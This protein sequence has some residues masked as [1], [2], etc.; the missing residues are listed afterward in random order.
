M[1]NLLALVAITQF[2]KGFSP[3][4]MLDSY[5][6]IVFSI[7][8]SLCLFE[9]KHVSYCEGGINIPSL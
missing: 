2:F 5:D 1:A 8:S 3:L 4:L 6:S 7:S 9:I